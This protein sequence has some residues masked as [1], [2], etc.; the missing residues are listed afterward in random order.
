MSQLI[1]WNR[2]ADHPRTLMPGQVVYH[3]FR[4]VPSIPPTYKS[5]DLP[6]N[7]SS[8]LYPI[9]SPEISIM[10]KRVASN[11]YFIASFA[12]LGGM[13]F[14]FDIS[15]ISGV[16]E[17][18]QCID[19]FHNPDHT[20]RRYYCCNAWWILLWCAS[21]WFPCRSFQQEIH[22]SDGRWDL[23]YRSYSAV[24]RSEYRNGMLFYYS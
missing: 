8:I 17:T 20:T 24:R 7:L 5:I 11:I 22:H 21:I 10:S 15:S 1:G 23:V 14:G 19:Y 3:Y 6:R 12:T 9:S 18:Q 13:L 2:V 4:K 16:I